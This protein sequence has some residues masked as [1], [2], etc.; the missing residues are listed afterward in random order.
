MKILLTGIN[1]VI[2]SNLA[3]YLSDK[4]YIIGVGR[5][6]C[7]THK[8]CDIYIKKDIT[9]LSFGEDYKMKDIDIIVHCAALINGTD[10]EL[11]DINCYGTYKIANFAREVK[12]KKIIYISSIPII[13]MPIDVPITEEHNVSPLTTY[14]LT[15]YLGEQAIS[16]TS[17]LKYYTL[18]IASPICVNMPKNK[19]FS[20]I[21]K[22]AVYNEDI[23]LYGNINRIQNY[24]HVYDIARVIDI[25]SESDKNVGIYN[26]KG[27]SVSNYELARLCKEQLN[28]S[29]NIILEN[30]EKDKDERW[31]V[32]GEKAYK[33]LGYKPKYC[34][35]DM[36]SEYSNMLGDDL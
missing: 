18:R 3:Q 26:I 14:H 19:I 16:H 9:D 25:I 36:I 21:V 23:T 32:S 13:G 1:G 31:I 35:K 24:I 20:S 5:N 2:G 12:C 15:K 6:E 33:E 22:R 4:Y 27:E 29:S 7:C 28:S 30:V 17:N 8:Y 11:F 10:R 34:I